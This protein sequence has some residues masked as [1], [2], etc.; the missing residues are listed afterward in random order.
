MSAAPLQYFPLPNATPSNSTTNA[1]NY[2]AVG[3]TVSPVRAWDVRIDDTI[4]AKSSIFARYSNRLFR[5]HPHLLPS[6]ISAAPPRGHWRPIQWRCDWIH[7]ALTQRT[8]LDVRFGFAVLCMTTATRVSDFRTHLLG[9]QVS[10]TQRPAML[11]SPT[12]R[13]STPVAI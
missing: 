1:N 11:K 3:T 6:A 5:L 8:V 7:D 10:S 13:P 4:N 9:C 12:F 2:Y